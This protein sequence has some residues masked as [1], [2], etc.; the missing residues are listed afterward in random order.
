MCAA[1]CFPCSIDQHIILNLDRELQTLLFLFRLT[2]VIAKLVQQ[3]TVSAENLSLPYPH[4]GSRHVPLRLQCSS[5]PMK[6]HKEQ[7]SVWTTQLEVRYREQIV[8]MH[9]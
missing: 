5:T 7:D 2:P 9:F 6:T 1:Q 3:Y 8:R 4:C